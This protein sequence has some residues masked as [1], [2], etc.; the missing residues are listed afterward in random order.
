MDK[1]PQYIQDVLDLIEWAN[2]N[3]RTS[4]WAKIRADAGHPAPFNL[5]YIG[6]G[7][8]DMIS[9]EFKSDLK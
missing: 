8:E 6:L 4:K 2:G 7:N 9:E 1:M 5:K 3:P